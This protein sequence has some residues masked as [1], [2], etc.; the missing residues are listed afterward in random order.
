MNIP[1]ANAPPALTER[2]SSAVRPRG[3]YERQG[4]LVEQEALERAE[5]ACSLTRR[6]G[7]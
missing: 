6:R 4:I 5:E 3:R 2:L 1:G 7:R